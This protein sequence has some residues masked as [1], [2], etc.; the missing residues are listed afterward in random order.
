MLKFVLKNAQILI[1]IHINFNF[2]DKNVLINAYYLF[3]HHK[4]I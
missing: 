4:D 3:L 1:K 2:K